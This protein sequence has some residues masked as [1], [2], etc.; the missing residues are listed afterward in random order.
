MPIN[1]LID[2]GK[3]SAR[4]GKA[5][6]KAVMKKM[7]VGIVMGVVKLL[8]ILIIIATISAVIGGFVKIIRGDVF[9]WGADSTAKLEELQVINTD[10]GC[11]DL[12]N[13]II[14]EL[15]MQLRENGLNVAKL[16]MLG[17]DT[18]ELGKMTDKEINEAMRKY[19]REYYAA[20]LITQYPNMSG[21][22]GNTKSGFLK[23][24]DDL[25]NGGKKYQYQGC[26]TLIHPDE[27]GNVILNEDDKVTNRYLTYIPEEQFQQKCIDSNSDV[28]DHFTISGNTIKVAGYTITN[29]VKQ[30]Q[31]VALSFTAI[32]S[33]YTM[34]MEFLL[35]MNLYS[36][37]PEFTY[38]LAKMVE[39]SRIVLAVQYNTTTTKQEM[40]TEYYEQQEVYRE[41][42]VYENGKIKLDANGNPIM[43]SLPTG[44]MEWVGPYYEDNTNETI[45]CSPS[46]QL[47]LADTWI[48]RKEVKYRYK[49]TSPEPQEDQVEE[50]GGENSNRKGTT[51]THTEITAYTYEEDT[52][53]TIEQEK[54]NVVLGL[55][56]NEEGIYD[57]EK[58]LEFDPDNRGKMKYVYY[59][60]PKKN[61]E[62]SPH[63]KLTTGAK[64]M[65]DDLEKNESTQNQAEIM[66]YLMNVYMGPK[67]DFGG[68]KS[69]DELKHLFETKTFN[70]S[71]SGSNLLVELIHSLE[72]T[73]KE[74]G[75]GN[76]ICFDD[77]AGTPTI[78]WGVTFGGG[79]KFF[80][81]KGIFSLQ[82]GDSISKEIIDEI[83]GKIRNNKIAAVEK[84]TA[85]LNLTQYQKDALII[86]CYNYNVSGFREAYNA[87]WKES[88][89]MYGTNVSGS[90]VKNTSDSIYNHPLYKNYMCKPTTSKGIHMPGLVTQRNIEWILFRTGNYMKRNGEVIGCWTESSGSVEKIL[91]KAYEI[92]DYMRHNGYSYSVNGNLLKS[93]FSA[94]KTSNSHVVCCATYVSWVLQEAGYN[95]KCNH[96]SP[97]LYGDLKGMFT[98]V[99]SYDNLQAGDI[100]FMNTTGGSYSHV[101]IYAGNGSWY[102]A[103]GNDSIQRLS[104]P[105]SDNVRAEFTVALRPN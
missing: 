52:G 97:G 81:E 67:Y 89:D 20:E 34:P 76:Y 29:G 72:G 93:S 61:S 71:G 78:G 21:D 83:E 27:N 1:R 10:E 69:F 44:E 87:Y 55:L 84:E 48:V 77:G 98:E 7:I 105:Y 31:P 9:K 70:V 103:G 56:K 30:Y 62:E 90:V 45:S 42:Y 3:D 6:M 59:P 60:I 65:I 73:P 43:Q 63:S 96:S 13:E 22:P 15:I 54:T 95:I 23:L 33:A 14:D 94:S 100:V 46:V 40:H 101:Q 2:K 102:N 37:N 11:L 18:G 51:T 47:V 99:T 36:E 74:D 50:F 75:K 68:A 58:L 32:A 28:E 38:A 25:L 66:K 26:I 35:M 4:Q 19:I 86:R 12:S 104:Y 41:E 88:D 53:N 5:R 8:P 82:I 49:D 24:L 17:D 16:K 79:K 92:S 39:S 80:E 64:M 57:E 91:Q 85:G